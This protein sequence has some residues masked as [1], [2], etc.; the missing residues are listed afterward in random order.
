MLVDRT[1]SLR[2]AE[3]S[4]DAS[5]ICRNT[6]SL[7]LEQC[8]AGLRVWNMLSTTIWLGHCITTPVAGASLQD[9]LH[10]LLWVSCH[11]RRGR[12]TEQNL[13]TCLVDL[14]L[15]NVIAGLGDS[16]ALVAQRLARKELQVLPSLRS[17]AG[18][19]RRQADPVNRM[20]L[21]YRF[22]AFFLEG[23]FDFNFRISI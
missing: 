21:L 8:L 17:K 1:G 18:F 20:I 5:G 3:L 13:L 9:V 10:F 15:P 23:S 7:L 6:W 12:A 2:H 22:L 16:L 14:T 4:F 11:P 19:A